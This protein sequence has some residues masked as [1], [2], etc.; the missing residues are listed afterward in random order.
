LE[1][2]LLSNAGPYGVK[3]RTVRSS[4]LAPFELN[5]SELVLNYL[6]LLW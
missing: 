1:L 6:V 3:R 5:F 4:K 2:C